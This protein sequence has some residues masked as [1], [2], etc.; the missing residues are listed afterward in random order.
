[1]DGWEKRVLSHDIHREHVNTLG[2]VAYARN[3]MTVTVSSMSSN[4]KLEWHIAIFEVSIMLC[5][6]RRQLF[7]RVIRPSRI[8][9]RVCVC[10]SVI[11]LKIKRY[12]YDTTRRE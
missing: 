1:M 6:R 5:Q 7:Q 9:E 10:P 11:W 2:L 12:S 4:A 3:S 8:G